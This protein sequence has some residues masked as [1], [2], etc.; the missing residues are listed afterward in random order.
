MNRY[1]QGGLNEP[2]LRAL[3]N[4]GTWTWQSN[5]IL[6]PSVGHTATRKKKKNHTSVWGYAN[7]KH[8]Q[9]AKLRPNRNLAGVTLC[10]MHY[11][12]LVLPRKFDPFTVSN[13]RRWGEPGSSTLHAP[14]DAWMGAMEQEP[15]A[16][17]AASSPPTTSGWEG[18]GQGAG[19]RKAGGLHENGSSL[20][21][22]H[23]DLN[24]C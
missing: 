4:K 17:G 19:G 16:G 3:R 12:I 1:F 20:P 23:T 8:P 21:S 6:F 15:A 5:T 7:I 22:A 24:G 14:R 9:I 11:K 18:W 2:S 10:C 13:K